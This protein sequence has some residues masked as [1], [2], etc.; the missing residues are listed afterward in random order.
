MQDAVSIPTRWYGPARA[1]MLAVR[2]STL[3]KTVALLAV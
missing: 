1:T 2:R 3:I